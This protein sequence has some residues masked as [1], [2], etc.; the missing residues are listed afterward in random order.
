M[1]YLTEKNDR[2][3]RRNARLLTALIALTMFTAFAYHAGFLDQ[4][5]MEYINPPAEVPV[6]GPVAEAAGA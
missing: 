5:L 2:R 6:S 4:V 1:T 3:R